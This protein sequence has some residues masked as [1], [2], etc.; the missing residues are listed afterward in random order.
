M[1]K[2]EIFLA[3]V[4]VSDNSAEISVSK[5]F[6]KLNF[7]ENG[8]N[9]QNGLKMLMAQ[10]WPGTEISLSKNWPISKSDFFSADEKISDNSA[11]IS[12]SKPYTKLKFAAPQVKIFSIKKK[13]DSCSCIE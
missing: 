12:F 9:F 10:M 11:K 3:D 8:P 4:K 1:G 7:S 6:T 13:N 5:P 2:Y